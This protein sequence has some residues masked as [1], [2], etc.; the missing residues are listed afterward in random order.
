MT[1]TASQLAAISAPEPY[2]LVE[3]CPGAGKSAVLIERIRW[4][5]RNG[6]DPSR[7]VAL[8]YT[9]AAA[10]V[11]I[12]RLSCN[13]EIGFCGTLHGWL[14][15]LL[16]SHGHLIGLCGPISVIDEDEQ[17]EIL[18]DVLEETAY[19]G[20]VKAVAAEVSKGPVARLN[21]MTKEQIAAEAFFQRLKADGIFTYDMI[22][23]YG[24]RLLAK[25]VVLDVD[26][27]L[28]DEAADL[29]EQDGRIITI[30]GIP[31]IWICGDFDQSIFGWR[32]RLRSGTPEPDTALTRGQS[33][34]CL[35]RIV[36]CELFL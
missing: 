9:C 16:T 6:T 12:E 2:C 3:A 5:V 15:R 8:T 27:L 20:A 25:G 30:T 10:A 13:G 18:R 23:H 19:R 26:H 14:L 28:V 24:E 35:H 34:R 1:L 11:I 29:T 33:R 36:R 32:S 17:N 21:P 4:I 31:N 7:V 22:L